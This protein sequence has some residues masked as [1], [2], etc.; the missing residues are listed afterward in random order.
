MIIVSAHS[1]C[2]RSPEHRYWEEIKGQ[3]TWDCVEKV[4]RGSPEAIKNSG[5]IHHILS[6]CKVCAPIHLLSRDE[7]VDER[8]F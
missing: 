5:S 8:M 4:V 7:S 1:H 6:L 2:L 3:N